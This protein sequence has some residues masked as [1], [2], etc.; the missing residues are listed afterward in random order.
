MRD[1][2]RNSRPLPYK[3]LATGI[4]FNGVIE[5]HKEDVNER[6][7]IDFDNIKDGVTILYF[8]KDIKEVA[9]G[10]VVIS[11]SLILRDYERVIFGQVYMAAYK[12]DL[13]SVFCTLSYYDNT[14][15]Y[16]DIL[17]VKN[18]KFVRQWD[19]TI[20]GKEYADG[21]PVLINKIGG[22]IFVEFYMEI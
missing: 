17:I 19:I 13:A 21:M 1:F 2:L 8:N 6:N 3:T 7:Q 14:S 10:N 5:Y 15:D 20:D 12:E 18:K 22:L 16:A 11:L 9:S 4:L